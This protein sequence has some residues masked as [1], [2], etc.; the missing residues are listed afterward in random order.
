MKKNLE[1]LLNEGVIKKVTTDKE[2]ISNSISLAERDLKT[3]LK[4]FKEKDFD[5][6][7]T[8]SYNA[9]LQAGRALMFSHGF[10]PSGSFKHL[11]VSRFVSLFQFELGENL[12]LIFDKIRKRRHI[13]VYDFSETVSESE[14]KNAVKKSSEFVNKIKHLINKKS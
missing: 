13:A 5:W 14:A 4:V 2:L 1:N 7:L 11:A 10:R 12:I 3:A 8:I 9:M 6:T